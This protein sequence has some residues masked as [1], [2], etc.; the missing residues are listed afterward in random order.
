M[1]SGVR[2][3]PVT[4]Q[5]FRSSAHPPV[6]FCTT[7]VMEELEHDP[8]EH[9]PVNQVLAMSGMDFLDATRLETREPRSR[10]SAWGE[11]RIPCNDVLHD[12]VNESRIL[13]ISFSVLQ[14]GSD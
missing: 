9:N 7:A 2:P 8:M 14:G 4:P 11:V 6:T 10:H 1:T 3:A 13:I 12:G 5:L